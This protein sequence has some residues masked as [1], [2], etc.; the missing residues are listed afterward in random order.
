MSGSAAPTAPISP[1]TFDQQPLRTRSDGPLMHLPEKRNIRKYLERYAEPEATFGQRLERHTDHILVIPAQNETSS[2]LDGIHPA[3]NA[4]SDRGQRTLCIVVINATGEAP[5]RVHV[6][7]NNLLKALKAHGQTIPLHIQDEPPCWYVM[8]AGFDIV[9]IDRT[10]QGYRLP[11]REGVGLARKIG[12][13]VALSSLQSL[14]NQAQLIHMSDCDVRLPRDYFDIVALPSSAAIV[15]RFHHEPCGDYMID[16][17]HARYEIYLRYYVLGLRY[18]GSPY[19]F[20]SIGS[21]IAAAPT[22]YAGVRGVPKRQAGEDFYLLNKLAKLGP[23]QTATTSPITIRAR[24]SLRVPFGTGRATHE[25]A[26]DLNAYRIYTPRIFDLLKAW[27]DAL[28]A[29]D[30]T[31]PKTAFDAVYQRARTTLG[32]ADLHR[33]GTALLAIDAPKALGA[34]AAHSSSVKVRRKW[35][36]DW[37][38]GFRTLKFLHALRETGLAD[39]PWQQAITEASFCK[40]SDTNAGAFDNNG[41]STL[42]TC[43]RLAQLEEHQ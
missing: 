22:S 26:K 14:G 11:A 40:V 35:A 43:R 32:P 33:L 18:A 20:H 24:A 28:S 15:Y 27:L 5:A 9:L 21:C 8:A 16:E 39:V 29:F 37:F 31:S 42:G 30:D 34:A 4:V 23:I 12:C 7:N 2:F 1:A 13:D 41:A 10:S 17:A 19:A 3:L 36:H 25:I 6:S 38:D